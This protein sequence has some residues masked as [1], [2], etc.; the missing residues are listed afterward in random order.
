M[1]TTEIAAW[2]GSATGMLSLAWNI[3]T[4]VTS[5]PKLIITARANLVERPPQ[6]HDPYFLK[7][8]V[9]NVGSQATTLTNATFHRYSS[10]WGKWYYKPSVFKFLDRTRLAKL[11]KPPYSRDAVLNEFRG[12]R[13]PHK[14]EVG[15]E[16]YALLEQDDSFSEWLT[17]RNFYCAVSHSFSKHPQSVRVYISPTKSVKPIDSAI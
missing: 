9:Q 13:F 7:I 16:W 17:T 3:Y 10:G 8:T 2:L 1:G 15:E 5:G 6:K 14:L 12:K 4:K 11:F